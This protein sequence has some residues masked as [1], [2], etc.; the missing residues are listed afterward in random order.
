MKL[1]HLSEASRK[2]PSILP[3]AQRVQGIIARADYTIA[4]ASIAGTKNLL[5]RLHGYGGAPRKPL[6][7]MNHIA[8]QDLWEHPHTR[9]LIQLERELS[10]KLVD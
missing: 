6:P 10:D 5:E 7:A 8:A 3:E 1:H 9:D 2:D 4:K